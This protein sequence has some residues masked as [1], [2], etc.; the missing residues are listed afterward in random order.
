MT[1]EEA[2]LV[3]GLFETRKKHFRNAIG[4]IP[5]ST[6][7]QHSEAVEPFSSRQIDGITDAATTEGEESFRQRR[8]PAVYHG[9]KHAADADTGEACHDWRHVR[10][11]GRR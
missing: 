9:D 8:S 7:K 1:H 10:P 5:L 3:T 2:H 4:E 6:S 11:D